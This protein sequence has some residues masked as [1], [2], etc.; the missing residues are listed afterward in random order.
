M[1]VFTFLICASSC[2]SE[3]SVPTAPQKPA[4]VPPVVQLSLGNGYSNQVNFQLSGSTTGGSTV[5]VSGGASVATTTANAA[6]AFTASVPLKPNSQNT[7][8]VTA[9]SPAGLTSSLVTMIIR[10]DD[11]RPVLN[12]LYPN[13]S[14]FDTDGDLRVNFAFEYSDSFPGI[15][16]ISIT[17]DRAIGGGLSKGGVDAGAN[18]ITALGASPVIHQGSAT[19]NAS[20]DH[21]FPIGANSVV[22]SVAD[23]AGN[24]TA[25]T[26]EIEVAGTE[27]S[28]EIL[29]PQDGDVLT[30]DFVITADFSDVAGRITQS[31][32]TFLANKPLIGLLSQDGTQ[33]EGA[34][35]GQNFGHAFSM[36][37]G[38]PDTRPHATKMEMSSYA[39]PGG[40]TMI[41]SQVFDLAGNSSQA[42]TITVTVPNPTHSVLVVNSTAQA[43]ATGHTISLGFNSFEAFGGLQFSLNF[44]P[45]VMSLDSVSSAG[46]APASPFYEVSEAGKVD[47]VVVDLTGDPIPS[48]SGIVLN[49]YASISATA[50]AQSMPLTLSDVQVANEAGNPINVVAR[51]GVLE[52][53]R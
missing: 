42:D 6:G 21:E 48:G 4:P 22:I 14:V 3:S 29:Q 7:L 32:L 53:Q 26:V 10:H 15:E 30:P 52:V 8:S 33:A 11:G 37:G 27:P 45:S 20:L 13:D 43:G 36:T 17:N 9:T 38:D 41:I 25:D 31:G 35:V 28:F 39:F 34:E 5:T 24:V 18:I 2:G 12:V 19:Y 23:S 50:A 44:D 49:V 16:I 40:E 1:V 47:I 51:D 46:R